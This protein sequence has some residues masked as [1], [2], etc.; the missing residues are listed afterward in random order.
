MGL[1]INQSPRFLARFGFGLVTVATTFLL[2]KIIV[3]V[4]WTGHEPLFAQP[5]WVEHWIYW[6]EYRGLSG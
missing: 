2:L 1:L 3:D 6:M 4:L 5:V